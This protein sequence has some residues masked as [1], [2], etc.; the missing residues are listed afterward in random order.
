M[1][2]RVLLI[3]ALVLVL[4]GTGAVAWVA[5]NDDDP[6]TTALA[7]GS[8]PEPDA[9]PTSAPPTDTQPAPAPQQPA[10][11][12]SDQPATPTGTDAAPTA[13][14]PKLGDDNPPSGGTQKTHFKREPKAKQ[15]QQQN[16]KPARR[17]AVPPAQQFSGEGNASLGTVDVKANSL[18]KWK[19]RGR[20]EIRFGREAFPIVAPTKSGQLVLPPFLFEKVRVIAG[21]PW[22][23]TISP[24]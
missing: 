2:A 16:D 6:P 19:A 22:K 12:Q 11:E 24:Q 18:L 4:C 23:I 9:G 3:A 15:Q 20:L 17:F 7:P 10:P 1:R 8:Q 5:A 21:G 13:P 14:E